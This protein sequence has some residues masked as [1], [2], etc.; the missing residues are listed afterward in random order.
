MRRDEPEPVPDGWTAGVVDAGGIEQ[1]HVRTGGDGPTLVVA[2]GVFDDGLCRA[3]LLAAFEGYDGLAYDARGHGRSGAPDPDAGAGYG[4]EARAAD[5]L[6]LLD[7]L[8]IEDPVLVG[9]SMGG[10]TVAAAAARRPD[11]PRAVVLVDPAGTLAETRE[12]A[13]DADESAAGVSRGDPAAAARERIERWRTTDKATLLDEEE[14]LRALVTAGETDLAGRLADA[15]RRLRPAVASVFGAGSVDVRSAFPR[16]EAPTLVLRA[17]VDP[18]ARERDREDVAAISD[19]R[20]V[21]VDGAG[22][23]VFRDRRAAATDRLRSF[24]ASIGVAP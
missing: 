4:P 10:D 1:F 7:A 17:D 6:A 15:R 9:H 8:E 11:L 3:P 18:A 12:S 20:L 13:D 21:H 16:V 23:T 22:H 5:L 24:L 19:G 2:H 14:E